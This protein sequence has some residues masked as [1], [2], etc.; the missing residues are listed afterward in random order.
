MYTPSHFLETD[1]TRL[2]WLAAQNSFG[3][4]VS[5]VQS[6]PFASHLPVLYHREGERVKLR[7]HWARPNPQWKSIA[8]QRALFIFH[9]PH[10]YISPR[11]YSNPRQH[12]PTWDYAVTHVYGSVRV[13]D[14]PQ[15]LAT[16]VTGLSIRYEAG[17][18]DP[19]KYEESNGPQ[20]LAG[21]IGFEL[22]SD[23]IEIKFKLNQNHPPEN[24]TGAIK[25]LAT[26]PDDN[27]R[28]IAELMRDAMSTRRRR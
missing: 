12:V 10:A 13:I 18:S 24:V 9:G 16:I 21:I 25:A 11:W 20:M 26:Q 7:G 3:T 4:L 27:S 5:L 15:E 1:L 22:V 8:G 23:A 28:A 6:D 17:A 19:W 14:D 2:D